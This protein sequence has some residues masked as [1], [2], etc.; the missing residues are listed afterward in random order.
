MLKPSHPHAPIA[1]MR[2]ARA[3]HCALRLDDGD[4]L[5]AGG[6]IG[7]VVPTDTVERYHVAQNRWETLHAKPAALSSQ[8]LAQ[9]DDGQFLLVGGSTATEASDHVERLDPDPSKISWTT[10]QHLHTAR[11]AHTTTALW[12]GRG[13]VLVTGGNQLKGNIGNVLDVAELL[14][15][16]TGKWQQ[17][18]ARSPRMNHTA[19]LLPSGKVLIVGGYAPDRALRSCELFDPQSQCFEPVCDLPVPRMQHTATLLAD[20]RVMVVAGSDEPFGPGKLE[21]LVYDPIADH[22]TF[23]RS[24]NREH[25]GHTTTQLNDRT[26]LVAGH[27]APPYRPSLEW[28]DPDKDTWTLSDLDEPTFRHSATLLKG[29]QGVLICGGQLL[30]AHPAYTA[31]CE[32]PDGQTTPRHQPGTS[33]G[34]RHTGPW[35]SLSPDR[36][37]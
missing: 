8:G 35:E 10:Y 34:A 11:F 3:Y 9:L 33:Y 12:P 30:T 20:G 13:K 4:V 15:V 28:Y 1:D 37:R 29:N 31:R 6:I 26:L 21:T 2:T 36:Q 5:V 27:T 23:G 7:G 32:H 24:L 22:W 18:K 16:R 25:L 17:L 14:D 19:T